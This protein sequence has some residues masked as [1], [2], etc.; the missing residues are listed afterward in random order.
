M[1]L[2]T[3]KNFFAT[4]GFRVDIVALQ[5]FGL[6][7]CVSVPGCRGCLSR[8]DGLAYSTSSRIVLPVIAMG[9]VCREFEVSLL[10]ALTY[11]IGALIFIWMLAAVDHRHAVEGRHRVARNVLSARGIE[12]RNRV[13]RFGV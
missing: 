1:I 11:P 13:G 12:A 2:G 7:L 5:I 6:G 9:G 4:T 3:T 10:Y 8:M